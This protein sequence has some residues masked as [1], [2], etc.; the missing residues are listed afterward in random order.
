MP[1]VGR[2]VPSNLKQAGFGSACRSLLGDAP[3]NFMAITT[4][5][6]GSLIAYSCDEGVH[7]F[8]SFVPPMQDSIFS[9]VLSRRLSDQ[10]RHV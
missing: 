5:E 8:F 10:G 1:A 7:R 6:V 9:T 2:R 3:P 4:Y